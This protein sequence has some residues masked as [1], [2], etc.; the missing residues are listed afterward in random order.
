MA[1]CDCA[2]RHSIV[3]ESKWGR[4]QTHTTTGTRDSAVRLDADAPLEVSGP[5]ADRQPT[6]PSRRRRLK[7]AGTSRRPTTTLIPRR[8][9]RPRVRLV[10]MSLWKSTSELPHASVPAERGSMTAEHHGFDPSAYRERRLQP[11]DLSVVGHSGLG[12]RYNRWLYR[13]RAA[14]FRRLLRTISLPPDARVLDVG[15]GTGFYIAEWER[16]GFT[17]IVG[18]DLTAIAVER[19]ARRFPGANSSAGTPLSSH[20]SSLPPSMRSPLSA[21]SSTSSM[22]AAIELRWRTSRR[23]FVPA[24]TC[25]CPKISSTGRLC[26]ASIR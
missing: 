13:V 3:L 18:S 12:L 22:T 9:N 26:R 11:F 4:F 7:A 25:S 19:L 2:A 5:S 6:S 14:V 15:S 23:C 21:S 1:L 16:A 20:S 10:T 17:D 24:A 8:S